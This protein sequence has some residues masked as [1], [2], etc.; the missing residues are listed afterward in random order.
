LVTP[1]FPHFGQLPLSQSNPCIR[2]CQYKYP[3]ARDRLQSKSRSKPPSSGF[4]LSAKLASFSP[5]SRK[6]RQ[7]A[8]AKNILVERREQ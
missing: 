2:I 5:K 1:C 3:D 4:V 8:M 6:Q 7:E